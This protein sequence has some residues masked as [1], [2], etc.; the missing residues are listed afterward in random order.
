MKPLKLVFSAF[1]PYTK[2]VVLDFADLK[3][4]SF[5][6]I[7][8]PTG[9]GKTTILDAMCFA[10]YGDA[11]GEKREAKMLRSNQADAANATEVDFT[12]A[13]GE[14][15]YRVWRSPEQQRAK[16]RGTGTTLSPA[17]ALLYKVKVKEMEE[18]L[19]VQGYSK[20]TEHLEQLLGFKSNQFRQVVLLPQGEF[21][22]LL[23]ANSAQRQEIMETLFKT[24]FYRLIEEQLKA[25]AKDI[26][27]AQAEFMKKQQFVL[28]EARVGSAEELAEQ[29]EKQQ[30]LAKELQIKATG[31]QQAQQAA[32]KKAADGKLLE[33]RF[34]AAESAR[35]EKQAC[36]V[37]LPK[38][39]AGRKTYELAEKA[40]V[41]L[42][43][44]KQ[45]RE[46][47]KEDESNKLNLAARQQMAAALQVREKQAQELWQREQA[48]EAQRKAADACVMQLAGFTAQLAEWTAASKQAGQRAQ[49]ADKQAAEKAVAEKQ[50]GDLRQQIQASQAKQQSLRE[51]AQGEANWQAECEKKERERELYLAAAKL[52][53]E[54]Q[55]ASQACAEKSARAGAA[56][57]DYQ[58]RVTKQERL[59]HLFTEGQAAILAGT[60]QEGKPCP[61][62][63]SE[64]HPQPAVSQ[65][66]LPGE[67]E[68][69]AAQAATKQADVKRQAVQR[70]FQQAQASWE[71]L[72]KQCEANQAV[73]VELA[74]LEEILAAKEKAALQYQAA[75]AANA[76]LTVLQAEIDQ[77]QMQEK[78]QVDEL[79][80]VTAAAQ[81]A[82]G[83]WQAALAVE[84]ERAGALPPEYRKIG[85]LEQAQREAAQRQKQLYDEFDAA[86]RELQQVRQLLAA[87]EAASDAA[88]K[89]FKQGQTRYR[90]AAADFTLRREKAGFATA[91]EYEQAA[92]CSEAKRVQLREHLRAFDDRFAAANELAAKSQAEI[93]GLLC[94]DTIELNKIL[95][96][97]SAAYN[98]AYAEWQ[99]IENEILR[100]QSK[101]KQLQE[102]TSKAAAVDRQYRNI[103]TLAAVAGGKNAHGITFQR[104]VLKSLLLDVIDASNMRLKIMSRGQYRLQP[105]DERA[106]KNAA[107]GL[108]MEVFDEYTGY[109]RPIATL[110]GGETF[111]A[112][113]CLALGL[114]DVVQSYAGGIHLD[115]ILVDEGFGTLDPEALDMALRALLELQKGGRLVGIISHVP[116]LQERID[117]RLEVTKDRQG[118][119]AKF[120]VG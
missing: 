65:A 20:V 36:E 105:T 120:Y 64:L 39:A 91:A 2:K 86:D 32:Q 101:S 46:F 97:T 49:A 21:R 40:A 68:V 6:L 90:E 78:N 118:S 58:R 119:T 87:A 117:A 16:K 44:E 7:H 3:G 18:K 45:V 75:R 104:F 42:D 88:A 114:A 61:V 52:Q 94:P 60:L 9:A 26:E 15:V 70:E 48:K 51:Q 8:G 25:K 74:P 73:L 93:A 47:A 63:G 62:C 37:L 35:Q 29:I 112:S 79:A 113:L 59:Q 85:L 38:V 14:A 53:Q 54:E 96:Q 107:G 55:A 89:Q 110:S 98:E 30:L 13:I 11:S 31:L 103:G 43:R 81:E 67:A 115:T 57:E 69:R 34:K 72:A 17:D 116:E 71:S 76:L 5:F 92:A 82:H 111:L 56:E 108:E 1:G 84:Q 100:D 106:R 66:I 12:F 41:L 10:L 27:A 102:L 19:L 22:Q 77:F 33:S 95:E 50:L 99:K 4:R 24:E 83:V 28:E 80:R 23:L 109:A